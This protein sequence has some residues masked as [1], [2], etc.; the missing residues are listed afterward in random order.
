MSA[1]KTRVLRDQT[2]NSLVDQIS[3][4]Q[5]FS[6]SYLR[7]LQVSNCRHHLRDSSRH[8]LRSIAISSIHQWE[9][10]HSSDVRLFTDDCLLYKHI[11]CDQDSTS[12]QDNL[13][14]LEHWGP[15][16]KCSSIQRNVYLSGLA[17][18]QGWS[19]KSLL[20]SWSYSRS[21]R[22]LVN[23]LEWQSARIL[24]EATHWCHSRKRPADPW[25]HTKKSQG[26]LPKVKKTEYTTLVRPSLVHIFCLGSAHH[27]GLPTYRTSPAEGRKI[28]LQQLY[29]QMTRMCIQYA[30]W[31]GLGASRGQKT[32]PPT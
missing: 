17:Q 18:T 2:A 30:A 25:I 21:R 11:A 10:M 19:G 1:P 13:T 24:M 26:M 14:A 29:G 20:S 5:P 28:C 3:S 9:A 31:P 16:G 7:R 6:K 27:C 4:A 12:H 32:Q 8:S 15:C 22:Q 23:I